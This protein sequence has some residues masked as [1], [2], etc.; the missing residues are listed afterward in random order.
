MSRRFGWLRRLFRRR[1]PTVVRPP[2]A[3]KPPATTAPARVTAPTVVRSYRD[4]DFY[5]RTEP[6]YREALQ[7]F[8]KARGVSDLLACCSRFPG[9]RTTAWMAECKRCYTKAPEGAAALRCIASL[10]VLLPR[11]AARTAGGADPVVRF[12]K[13]VIWTL[14][15]TDPDEAVP[16]LT[17]V[18]TLH[19]GAGT[20][21]ADHAVAVAAIQALGSVGGERTL[22]PL[23]L[24]RSESPVDRLRKAASTELDRV[25]ASAGISRTDVPEWRAETFELNGDGERR[26]ELARGYT[27]TVRLNPSGKVGVTFRQPNGRSL[28]GKPAAADLATDVDHILELMGNVRDVV[29]AERFRLRQLLADQRE[30]MVADWL[31][32]YIDHPVTG[33]LSRVLIWEYR[34]GTAD[35][36]APGIVRRLDDDGSWRLWTV[37]EPWRALDPSAQVRLLRPLPKTSHEARFWTRRLKELGLPPSADQL[38]QSV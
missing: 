20:R 37:E 6:G 9:T 36:W 33:T 38:G 11:S 7:D 32:H 16:I 1:R 12:V 27:A 14:S 23:R 18:A 25:L 19:S 30:L 15:L 21:R 13:G 29:R 8:A 22:A 10:E 26:I 35:T 24:I 3:I 4:A 2:A 28:A 34:A 17:R 5:W 31:R